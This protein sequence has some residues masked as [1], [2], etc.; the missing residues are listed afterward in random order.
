LTSELVAEN[1]GLQNSGRFLYLVYLIG[2]S[3]VGN[4]R[5][6]L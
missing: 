2:C 6:K 1:P 4:N 5:L 3:A